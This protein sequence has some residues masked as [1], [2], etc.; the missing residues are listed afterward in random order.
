MNPS[1]R[2]LVSV[3]LGLALG[4]ASL[5]A[6]QAERFTLSGST[7]K[8][9]NLIGTLDVGP[10]TGGAATAEVTR[11]GNDGA[12]LTVEGTGGTLKVL[13]PGSE[14]V[15]PS[16]GNRGRQETTLRVRD[17]GTFYGDDWDNN[18]G[19]KVRITTR[20]GG[21]DAR[22]DIRLL[23]PAGTR[24]ELN[25]GVGKV[26]LANVNGTISVNTASGDVEGT[27]TAGGLSVDTG[28]GDVT[29]AGH[30]GALSV[31]TGSGDI[32][33]SAIK[34]DEASFDTGSGE[35][36]IDG[37]TA[38]H[39]SVDTGSGDIRIANAAVR[40]ISL[41]TGSGDIQV[42][43]TGGI[44][45]LSVDTGSGDVTITAPASFNATVEIETSSGDI[46]TEFPLQVT[47]KGRDGLSGKIGSGE[48][49]LSVDTGSGDVTLRQRP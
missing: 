23:L 24:A 35:V 25:I 17:D 15:Y 11:R 22:A 4:S 37:I 26:T 5:A 9:Y 42:A 49:R 21:L 2:S 46:S 3:L 32:L 43:L 20:G 6:Q 18:S 7:I 28:S 19:R 47:R 45:D 40:G 27:T 41:D 34:S 12:K 29:V 39:L 36:K 8:V 38:A 1:A 10:A 30:N 33:L 14:F 31:D 48:G 13:Y 44:D 16:N